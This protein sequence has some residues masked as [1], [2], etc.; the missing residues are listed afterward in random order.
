[1]KLKISY[2]VIFIF[3][4][5]CTNVENKEF[6][7]FNAPELNIKKFNSNVLLFLQDNKLLTTETKIFIFNTEGCTTCI[8]SKLEQL[9]EKLEKTNQVYTIISNPTNEKFN[10]LSKKCFHLVTID[11]EIFKKYK[12]WHSDIYEYNINKKGIITSTLVNG[13]YLD[14]D[15]L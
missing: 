1:M 13:S 4:Y 12:I 2:I 15:N 7:N 10:V 14:K 6:Q 9:A 11:S 3:I 5:S 8:T